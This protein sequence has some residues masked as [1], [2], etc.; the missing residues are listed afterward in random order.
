MELLRH[1]PVN[2]P[3]TDPRSTSGAL[4]EF[5][6]FVRRVEPRLRVALAAT[7]G[8]SLGTG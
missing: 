2:E 8:A 6:E 1:T 4:D 5:T 7:F 3:P